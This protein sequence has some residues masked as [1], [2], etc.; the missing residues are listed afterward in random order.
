[1]AKFLVFDAR[2]CIPF[3]ILFYSPSFAK[4]GAS[5][6]LFLFFSVLSFYKYT[7]VVLVRRMRCKLAGP[8]RSGV[9]WWHRPQ[10]RLYRHR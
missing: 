2:A 6:G 7:L 10:R 1:M 4:L 8:V 3:V 5:I 9:A